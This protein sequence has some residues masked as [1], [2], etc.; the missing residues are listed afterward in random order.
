[1]ATTI[2]MI[3]ARTIQTDVVFMPSSPLVFISFN[4][5]LIS[6][7]LNVRRPFAKSSYSYVFRLLV[8]V[9]Y[10]QKYLYSIIVEAETPRKW[11]KPWLKA[12]KT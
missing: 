12:P 3:T 4:V 10:C 9:I 5:T 7:A 6:R 8:K 1:V 11:L 2:K